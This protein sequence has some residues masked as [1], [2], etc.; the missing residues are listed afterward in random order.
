MCHGHGTPTIAE[1]ETCGPQTAGLCSRR[2]SPKMGFTHDST[3][4]VVHGPFGSEIGLRLLPFLYEEC[5]P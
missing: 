1:L 4:G 2:A 5:K 3:E